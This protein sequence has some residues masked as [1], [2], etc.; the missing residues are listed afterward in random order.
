MGNPMSPSTGLCNEWKYTTISP[1]LKNL[2]FPHVFLSGEIK[3]CYIGDLNAISKGLG[4]P[5]SRLLCRFH[6]DPEKPG[7]LIEYGLD[8]DFGKS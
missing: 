4:G 7:I 5:K 3:I 6:V 8:C 1:M 2:V